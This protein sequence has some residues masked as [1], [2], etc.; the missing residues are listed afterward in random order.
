MNKYYPDSVEYR[1][2]KLILVVD[3][4]EA[5]VQMLTYNLEKEGYNIMVTGNG[6]DAVDIALENKPD[7]IL[8]DRM[9]PRIRW[10]Y[11]LQCN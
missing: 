8:M 3:D 11:C 7:L 6:T 1:A 9:L 2:K 10:T 5:I 4:E